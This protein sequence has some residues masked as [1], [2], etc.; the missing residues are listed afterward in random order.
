MNTRIRYGVHVWIAAQEENGNWYRDIPLGAELFESRWNALEFFFS[1][2]DSAGSTAQ[3]IRLHCSR[4][5]MF[6]ICE[7]CECDVNGEWEWFDCRELRVS[8]WH[9]GEVTE[10]EHNDELIHVEFIDLATLDDFA[11]IHVESHRELR[12]DLRKCTDVQ[13]SIASNA[14][15][16]SRHDFSDSPWL[17]H[18]IW[19]TVTDYRGRSMVWSVDEQ[20]VVA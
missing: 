3:E 4:G 20:R 12:V 18:Q 16:I 14:T 8:L 1:S 6:D 9:R 13:R 19:Y 17:E 2:L 10:V 5:L 7:F 11:R 15:R